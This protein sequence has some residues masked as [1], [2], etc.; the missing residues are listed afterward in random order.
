MSS[1]N[2]TEERYICQYNNDYIPF[3]TVVFLLLEKLILSAMPSIVFNISN[4]Q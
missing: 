1:G 3:A 4:L 2:L